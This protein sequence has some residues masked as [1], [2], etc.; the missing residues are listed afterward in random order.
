[1]SHLAA[2]SSSACMQSEEE[3]PVKPSWSHRFPC[4][5]HAAD[6]IVPGVKAAC[7]YLTIMKSKSN[8]KLHAK[9]LS[10]SER[11]MPQG[12][13]GGILI[14]V[15]G[16]CRLL[17]D[18]RPSR[19]D[20]PGIAEEISC[21][22]KTEPYPDPCQAQACAAGPIQEGTAHTSAEYGASSDVV[23]FQRSQ[24][25]ALQCSG[26]WCKRLQRQVHDG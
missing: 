10:M 6:L 7:I 14:L 18:W 1:M 24:Q 20:L 3:T 5:Q 25:S 11:E 13:S 12:H 15:W 23:D 4:L 16:A 21:C 19:H 22:D 9:Q 26:A 8:Q 2:S 17:A